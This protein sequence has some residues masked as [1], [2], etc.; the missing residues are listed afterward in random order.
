MDKLVHSTKFVWIDLFNK[1]IS[2]EYLLCISLVEL[3]SKSNCGQVIR[4]NFI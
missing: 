1:S 4:N 3:L 2:I